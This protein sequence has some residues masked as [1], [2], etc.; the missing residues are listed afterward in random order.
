MIRLCKTLVRP[1]SL[2]RSCFATVG[3]PIVLMMLL[4]TR[5]SV[6]MGSG[7]LLLLQLVGSRYA[8]PNDKIV[9]CIALVAPSCIDYFSTTVLALWGWVEW[10]PKSWLG[11][12]SLTMIMC[13]RRVFLQWGRENNHP[14]TN[15]ERLRCRGITEKLDE[16]EENIEDEDEENGGISAHIFWN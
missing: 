7:P 16:D 5:T 13:A 2:D 11:L 3:K 1:G 14:F 15:S 6:D 4:K 10:K 12:I 8:P 9:V